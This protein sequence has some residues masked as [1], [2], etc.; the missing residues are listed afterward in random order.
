MKNFYTKISTYFHP[1]SLI[2]TILLDLLWAIPE[3]F[4]TATLFGVAL[5]PFSI[6]LIFLIC[7]GAVALIQHH[8][9]GDEWPEALSKGAVL[10]LLAAVPFSI[11][12]STLGA[13]WG[14]LRLIYG[15]T[16]EIILLGKLSKSWREMEKTVRNL[17]PAD[18]RRHTFDE[19]INYLLAEGVFTAE[20]GGQ[21]HQIRRERNLNAHTYT[22]KTL[23]EL[24]DKV[25]DMQKN[26]TRLPQAP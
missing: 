9:A 19:I 1:G 23:A 15:V 16:P 18:Y 26:L 24:V 11:V 21:L 22:T 14:F 6:V 13:L 4:L 12:T 5:E 20:L 17:V 3:T 8:L 2:L 7:G 10:G 25:E